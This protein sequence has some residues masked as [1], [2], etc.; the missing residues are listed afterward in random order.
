MTT[1]AGDHRRIANRILFF[2]TEERTARELQQ[3]PKEQ[4]EQ[5]WADMKGNPENTYYRMHSEDH[6]FV[7]E[8]LKSLDEELQSHTHHDGSAA[9]YRM[10]V[11]QNPDFVDS[12]KLKFLRADDFDS[13]AAANRLLSH[14]QHKLDLF[15]PTKLGRDIRLDDLNV[16]DLESLR[17]GGLQLLPMQDHA[18]RGVVFTRHE[19]YLYKDH[20]NMVR[21]EDSLY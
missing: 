9:A 6:D 2:P 12:Q 10:A 20:K 17:A 21:I 18:T 16:D 5:V 4:R 3:L 7:K 19:N 11:E 8:R 15:G 13:V 1:L 14:F